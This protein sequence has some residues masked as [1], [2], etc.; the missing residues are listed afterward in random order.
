MHVVRLALVAFLALSSTA[1]L[2]MK[3]YPD[4]Q[5]HK[6]SYDT[7]GTFNA[8]MPVRLDVMFQRNG[9]DM[10]RAVKQVRPLIESALQ[11]SGAFSLSTDASAPSLRITINNVA[12]MGEAAKKGFL[13]ALT[14]GG[15]GST[16]DDFYE[17][18]IEFGSGNN[19]VQKTYKHVLHSTIGNAAAPVQGVPPVTVLAGFGIVVE[20]IT[21][22][23][24]KDL[25][26]DGKIS[27]RSVRFDR[28]VTV[29]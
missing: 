9:K 3:A 6:A 27:Q 28:F 25:K 29:R 12:D 19:L 24:I 11:K 21:L 10:P 2:S 5:F 15:K 23:F 16:V 14:F 20:D 7:L 8:V 22:N 26:D 4:P 13:T 1:C 18:K 17:A